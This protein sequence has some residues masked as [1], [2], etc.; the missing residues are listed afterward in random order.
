[1][2]HYRLFLKWPLIRF[3]ENVALHK[4]AWQL[5]PYENPRSRDLLNAS[6]AVDGLKSNLSFSGG[7]CTQSRNYEYE[8]IWRVDLGVVLGINHITLY[9]KTDNVA[10]GLYN[11][12]LFI[13]PLLSF[14]FSPLILKMKILMCDIF[15]MSFFL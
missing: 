13:Y 15:L 1:M 8:A 6:N 7:Q 2:C 5:H 10:W 3:L 12:Y 14:S 9:Y 11:V 4:S